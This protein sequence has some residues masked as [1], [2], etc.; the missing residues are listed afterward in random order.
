[1]TILLTD[2]DACDAFL[3]R[4]PLAEFLAANEVGD[5]ELV[6]DPDGWGRLPRLAVGERLT[7][8]GGAAAA[9]TV[10]RVA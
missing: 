6:D 3:W 9:C 1:M 4:G 10:E 8:G 5:E 2:P 7:L